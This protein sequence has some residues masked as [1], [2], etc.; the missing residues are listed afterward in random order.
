MR[1]SDFR[2][3]ADSYLSDEL[4]IETNHDLIRHL[5]SCADCRLE[6][7]A[8]RE[9][10]NK[11]RK[12]FQQA[13]ELQVPGEFAGNLR[14]ELRKVRQ[15]SPRSSFRTTMTRRAAFAAIAASLVIAAAL[16]FR[17]IQQRNVRPNIVAEADRETESSTGGS[18]SSNSTGRALVSAALT[19]NAIGDHRNCAINHRLKEKPIDLDEGGRSYDR[20]YINLVQAVMS[21]GQLPGGTTLVEAH[22]CIFNGQRFGHVILK[23]HDQLVSVLVTAVG[24]A[25]TSEQKVIGASKE[26]SIASA[27]SDVYRV[28]HFETAF[29]VVFVI[30]SLSEADNMAIAQAVAPSVSKHVERAEVA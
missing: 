27:G 1:C 7:A 12:G 19:E 17:A 29:H 20:A 9:L 22:S 3:L 16:G 15:R 8:R 28:A 30:S 26:E 14:D 13:A 24:A 2:E 23:Y 4:L 6:L 21:D 25:Q 11:L 5:E 10:R 18:E